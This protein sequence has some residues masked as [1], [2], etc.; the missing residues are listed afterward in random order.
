MLH[1]A[2]GVEVGQPG[3]LGDFDLSH[4]VV[5]EKLRE[6]NGVRVPL[7]EVVISPAVMAASPL[8]EAV[9]VR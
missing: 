3:R 5:A 2:L 8:L 6:R 7:A 9:V 1:R 4:P